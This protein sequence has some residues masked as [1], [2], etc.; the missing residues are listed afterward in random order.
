MNMLSFKK[1]M[2]NILANLSLIYFPPNCKYLNRYDRL[3][4]G[5]DFSVVQLKPS[6][7]GVM[8]LGQADTHHSTL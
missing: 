3:H 6:S 7:Q 8:R 4:M 2:F 1:D 5:P